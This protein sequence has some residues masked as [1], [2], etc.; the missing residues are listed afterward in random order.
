MRWRSCSD[1]D[2][3]NVE[4]EWTCKCVDGPNAGHSHWVPGIPI[5][6]HG[7]RRGR[8]HG[9][10]PIRAP[11]P[12][13]SPWGLSTSGR[14]GPRWG[15]PMCRCASNSRRAVRRFAWLAD[16]ASCAQGARVGVLRL[17]LASVGRPRGLRAGRGAPVQRFVMRRGSPRNA[18]PAVG[19]KP[20]E[21]CKP[22]E[23]WPQECWRSRPESNWGRRICNP[24]PNHLATGP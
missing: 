12:E 20:R 17:R 5:R 16:V 6:L 19:R 14:G 23:Y 18:S 13:S 9:Q 24:L 22:R 11:R 21:P 4:S 15:M 3:W 1:C 8:C 10:Q 7:P 2:A